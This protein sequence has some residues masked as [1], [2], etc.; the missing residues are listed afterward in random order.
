MTLLVE[1][2]LEDRIII[3]I[4]LSWPQIQV[5][6]VIV[7]LREFIIPVLKTTD[8]VPFEYPNLNK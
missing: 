7:L 2:L 8:S 1:L 4:L 3:V 5:V 6:R